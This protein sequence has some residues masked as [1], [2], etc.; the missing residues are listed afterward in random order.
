[1]STPC[2]E[3]DRAWMPTDFSTSLACP[4]S[5]STYAQ[6]TK[7]PVRSICLADFKT[8]A[9]DTAAINLHATTSERHVMD[10]YTNIWLNVAVVLSL[11]GI[12]VWLTL[13]PSTNFWGDDD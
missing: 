10:D 3:Q 11:A 8:S 4:W 5:K 12:A 9:K 7:R 6:Q 1:M 13:L 2:V